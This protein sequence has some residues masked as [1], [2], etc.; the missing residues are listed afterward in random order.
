MSM[1]NSMTPYSTQVKKRLS[2]V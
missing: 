1:R 2:S